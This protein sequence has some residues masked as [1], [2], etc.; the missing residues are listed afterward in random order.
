MTMTE[1]Q[2]IEQSPAETPES[3]RDAVQPFQRDDFDR[4][5]WCL[6]GL[7]VD[8]AD[9]TRAVSAIDDAVRTGRRLS[10]VTP[11]VNFLVRAAKCPQARQAILNADL[12]LV[13]GA[14]L[15]AMAR[16][17]GVPVRSRVAGSDLF[18]VLRRRPAFAGRPL[19]VFF[20][21]GREGSAEAAFEAVNRE[22]G[23][24]EAVGWLNP[25]FGD[26]ESMSADAIIDEINAA[27]ADF[28]VAALGAAK[29]Q[30]WIERNRHRL[31]APVTAHLGAVV[32]FAA[33]AIER[34]PGWVQRAGLE[35]LWRIKE[36]PSLWKR[37]FQDALS[38]AGLGVTGLLP[39]LGRGRGGVE[40]AP[41]I[42]TDAGPHET[43]IKLSGD[44]TRAGLDP[45]RKAFREAARRCKPVLLDFS[46]V[47]SVD[48]A[49]LGLL[50]M[51]EKHQVGAGQPVMTTGVGA[52]V[53][54]LLRANHIRYGSP[55]SQADEA[56][57]RVPSR[58]AAV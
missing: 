57:T 11:N 58:K 36:E 8:A 30:A 6:M 7:A 29:G 43:T 28:V 55:Q 13:D 27:D 3:A 17:L 47:R 21:G 5:V 56:E 39:Q 32:D 22:K 18:E 33:G 52:R 23:G 48:R 45:V 42:E 26:V 38:L 12:S 40:V 34:A 14:P 37:Y 51:L 1:L 54:A 44:L 15:V 16:L 49:F 9:V 10:F 41:R 20:F 19:R 53:A 50:L 4:D 31:N 35:W 2:P 25:G 46:A 24:V